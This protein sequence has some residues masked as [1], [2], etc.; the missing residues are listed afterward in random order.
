MK[1][2]VKVYTAPEVKILALTGIRLAVSSGDVFDSDRSW[3][4]DDDL[5]L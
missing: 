3:D 4:L 2:T 5:P 1:E